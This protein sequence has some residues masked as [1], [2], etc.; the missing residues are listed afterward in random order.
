MSIL[1]ALILRLRHVGG[2]AI[3]GHG[4][5]C[6]EKGGGVLPVFVVESHYRY[7]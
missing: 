3:A 2:L 5:A 1:G 4:V 6:E 7:L